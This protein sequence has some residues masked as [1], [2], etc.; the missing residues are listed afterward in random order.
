M[1]SLSLLVGISL[2]T[3]GPARIRVIRLW[4]IAGFQHQTV[5][6]RA[7]FYGKESDEVK[8]M[9]GYFYTEW[10]H[11]RLKIAVQQKLAIS[12]STEFGHAVCSPSLPLSCF[13]VTCIK[14]L[15]GWKKEG[16]GRIMRAHAV[17]SDLSTSTENI[18]LS[19]DQIAKATFPRT[20]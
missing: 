20:S 13:I 4:L 8:S 16:G 6:V 7:S 2:K 11:F 15:S 10:K 9:Q 5:F 12:L 17:V 19:Y 1:A 3:P 14:V 18:Q